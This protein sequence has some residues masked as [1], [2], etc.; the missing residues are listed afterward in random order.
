MF[1]I[2]EVVCYVSFYLVIRNRDKYIVLVVTYVAEKSQECS[3]WLREKEA[4]YGILVNWNNQNKINV[5]L[6]AE[7][8]YL[9]VNYNTWIE[10]TANL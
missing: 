6:S 3:C 4:T 10:T 7:N 5:L 9:G 2:Y 1:K 8:S